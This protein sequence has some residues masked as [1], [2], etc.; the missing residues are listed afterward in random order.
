[1]VGK[2][3]LGI[4]GLLSAVAAIG[5]AGGS[6]AQPIVGIPHD[7]QMNFPPPYTPLMERVES[8]TTSCW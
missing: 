4:L 7:W 6:Q 5:A 3:G 2:R 1:M 8:L